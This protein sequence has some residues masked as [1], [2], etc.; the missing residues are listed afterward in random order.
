MWLLVNDKY[1]NECDKCCSKCMD[2]H[3]HLCKK[4]CFYKTFK[5][6]NCSHK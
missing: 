4:S 6:K 3:T 5:C 1:K 2:K